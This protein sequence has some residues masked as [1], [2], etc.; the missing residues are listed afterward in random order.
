[1]TGTQYKLAVGSKLQ[2]VG[3]EDFGTKGGRHAFSRNVNNRQ[4]AILCIHCPQF[5][6]V[7]ET[8]KPSSPLPT[9]MMV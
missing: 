5:G 4:R 1:M 9:G 7:A 2:P 3:A 8:S 6:P